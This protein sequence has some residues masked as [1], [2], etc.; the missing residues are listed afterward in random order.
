M[1]RLTVFCGANPGT[2]P[3]YMQAAHELGI[4]LAERQVALVYGGASVGLMGACADAVLAHGGQAI[5]VMPELL[6]QRGIAHPK[7]NELI[8]VPDMQARKA[9]MLELADACLALPGGIGTMEEIF[10]AI[11]WSQLGL[12]RKP[13]AFYNINGYYKSLAAFLD[14]TVSEGFLS[15]GNRE[16]I[17]ISD[18]LDIIEQ[19][20]ATYVPP[21]RRTYSR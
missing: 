19:C 2:D 13:C 18:S 20:F 21:E 12:H 11:S 14:R 4:W 6:Q 1:K 5:G 8:V 16:K 10:D 15:G 7:L 17:I 3:I 9:K